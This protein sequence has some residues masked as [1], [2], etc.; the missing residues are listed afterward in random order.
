M[1]IFTCLTP[2]E[3]KL[4]KIFFRSSAQYDQVVSEMVEKVHSNKTYIKGMIGSR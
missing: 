2:N 1:R 3:T 4:R